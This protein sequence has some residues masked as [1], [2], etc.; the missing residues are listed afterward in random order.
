[1]K[2]LLAQFVFLMGLI[3]VHHTSWSHDN[4]VTQTTTVLLDN[5]EVTVNFNDGD[6]FKVLDGKH[7]R[8]RVRIGGFNALEAY[9]PVHQFANSSAEYL[10]QTSKKAT[11]MARNGSW[12]CTLEKGKDSYGRLLAICDDL[13]I[14]LIKHGLA[15]AYSVDENPATAEYLAAQETAQKAKKG[16]WKYGVPSFI[17]TSLHSADE[18]VSNTYNRL[19]STQDGRSEKWFHNDNYETCEVVCV[20]EDSCMTYVPFGQRYGSARPECLMGT[21]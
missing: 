2:K 14:D 4:P 20:E 10:Y 9:G 21:N 6:T 7:A 5:E 11:E 19:I 17:I 13:A 15:H 12:T 18:N 3:S 1:M 16:M 8:A